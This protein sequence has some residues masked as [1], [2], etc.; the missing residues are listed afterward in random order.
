MKCNK[1]QKIVK[2]DRNVQYRC[3]NK[4]CNFYQ[5]IVNE[6]V[7]NSCNLKPVEH[8]KPC[9][10]IKKKIPEYPPL[11]EQ[12]ASYKDA[13]AKW[14]KAGKPVRSEEEIKRIHTDYCHN[15][16]WYDP[17]Q[18]RCRGCGCKVTTGGMAIF[19]K[20]KMATEHC[21]REYW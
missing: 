15:C 18:K 2:K 11:M 16:D 19:N 17:D 3:L 13:I 14:S 12:L 5:Q 7:C 9:K 8:K 20:I 21:P 10:K 4:K 1:K 6:K